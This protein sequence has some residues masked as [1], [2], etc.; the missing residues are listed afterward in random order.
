M[1][2]IVNNFYDF[3]FASLCDKNPLKRGL[4]FKERI[5]SMRSNFPL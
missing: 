5:C 1:S 4:L 3:L 2:E